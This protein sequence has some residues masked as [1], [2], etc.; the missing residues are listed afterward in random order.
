MRVLFACGGTGGHINPAIAVA[1]MLRERRPDAAIRFAGA[2]HGM[3]AK[4]VPA[5]GFALDMV[6]IEGFSR[7]LSL[8]SIPR[9]IRAA[10]HAFSSLKW[11]RGII[12]D[13][14]PDVVVGTGGYASFPV[15]YSAAKLGIPTIIHESNAYPGLTTR[16]LASRVSRVLV[17]FAATRE[18]LKGK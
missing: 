15:L 9:N 6:D 5:E 17:N 10:R 8:S 3:E 12:T 18:Y 11:A 1:K 7:K 16:V 14:K 4:L 13:F 2:R